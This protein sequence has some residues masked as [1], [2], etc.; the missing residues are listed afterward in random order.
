M[1]K[2]SISSIPSPIFLLGFMASG[3]STVGRALAEKLNAPFIDL[4][5]K[6]IQQAGKTIG[7]IIQQEGEPYFRQLEAECLQKAA[8]QGSA[9]IA[10][11]GGAFMQSVNRELIA[12]TGVSIWL[13]APFELCWE[14]IQKD[15]VVRPLAP[16]IEETRH[17]YQQRIPVYQQA[18]IQIEVTQTSS[19]ESLVDK[20]LTYLQ[21]A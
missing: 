9:V 14:R 6:I 11:G 1:I 12:Q 4:D 3:K 2:S 21:T 7:E 10:L 13:N 15:A 5:E 17:R 20:I 16:T 19:P 8:V 18:Q